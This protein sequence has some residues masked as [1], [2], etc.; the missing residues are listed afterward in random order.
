MENTSI[1]ENPELQCQSTV[2]DCKSQ[3]LSEKNKHFRSALKDIQNEIELPEDSD[4]K[5]GLANDEVTGKDT[6]WGQHL[7][8]FNILQKKPAS[9]IKH[10][11]SVKFTDKLFIASKFNKRNPRKMRTMSSSQIKTGKTE[12]SA[13]NVINDSSVS[14]QFVSKTVEVDTEPPS[15]TLFTDR[16]TNDTK[17]KMTEKFKPVTY[18]AANIIRRAIMDV[19]PKVKPIIHERRIDKGWL[20]RCVEVDTC[21]LE[22]VDIVKDD[23]VT[24]KV[25]VEN[26]QFNSSCNL[27]YCVDSDDDVVCNSESEDEVRSKIKFS[28]KRKFSCIS[29][30]KSDIQEGIHVKKVRLEVEN[31]SENLKDVNKTNSVDSNVTSKPSERDDCLETKE[32][33]SQA[34]TVE[35]CQKVAKQVLELEKNNSFALKKVSRPVTKKEILEEKVKSGKANENFVR[36][37]IKKKVYVRGKKT[38][39]ATKYKK[40]QWKKKKKENAGY[41]TSHEGVMT[42]FKCGDIGHFA[43]NC[44]SAQKG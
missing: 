15:S 37:N 19:E 6:V 42:C 27:K 21:L 16:V 18:K 41:K 10:S 34:F 24:E 29:E 22:K 40:M 11:T 35:N 31:I 2:I 26:G 20:D 33:V 25:E 23:T 14:E 13:K 43:K 3:D 38:M 12:E 28:Y 44:H 36:I 8:K 30:N 9:T 17:F 4:L 39:N 1:C 7:N 32:H 5:K